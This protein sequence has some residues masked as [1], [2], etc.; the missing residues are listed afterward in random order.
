MPE[1]LRDLSYE[2]L[3]ARVKSGGEDFSQR[4]TDA[5]EA[6]QNK[7][8][9]EQLG[10]EIE[11]RAQLPSHSE[12]EAAHTGAE[13]SLK[14]GIDV[15]LVKEALEK[16]NIATLGLVEGIPSGG[17]DLSKVRVLHKGEP[18]V[19]FRPVTTEVSSGFLGL[20]KKQVPTDEVTV[21]IRLNNN[22]RKEPSTVLVAVVPQVE[23][24]PQLSE[25]DT[26][27]FMF[28]NQ[29]EYT[30]LLNKDPP[31]LRS[32]LVKGE[33]TFNRYQE[34]FKRYNGISQAEYWRRW[35]AHRENDPNYWRSRETREEVL[36]RIE[37]RYRE[38][39]AETQ[40]RIA[41]VAAE[42]KQMRAEIRRRRNEILGDS[43]FLKIAAEYT[44][45]EDPILKA[46]YV[47][48]LARSFGVS[49]EEMLK[50]LE[51]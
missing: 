41:Q 44:R 14:L 43:L 24:V 45:Q 22:T 26:G 33:L 20:E 32:K 1:T 23:G 49:R 36:G 47:D 8:E 21:I 9:L 46:F 2:K 15:T 42:V 38:L 13:S 4:H 18:Q 30:E 35:D 16:C 31:D 3:A 19:F 29:T 10:A 37:G 50:L 48:N 28:M 34:D 6:N 12:I 51:G 39:F 7:K 27:L 17:L 25:K 11:R 40:E 5:K